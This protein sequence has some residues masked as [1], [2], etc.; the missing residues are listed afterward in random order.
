MI[1]TRLMPV[2]LPFPCCALLA[3][4][5]CSV[6]E[7][8]A[9]Q[10]LNLD[11]IRGQIKA[12]HRE[13]TKDAARE[14][15]EATKDSVTAANNNLQT[16]LGVQAAKLT[17]ELN[18]VKATLNAS[19]Q[20]TADL[21]AEVKLTANAIANVKAVANVDLSPVIQAQ[22]KLTEDL[23]ANVKALSDL[24]AKIDALA[25]AQ[26][27]FNNSMTSLKTEVSAGRDSLVQT[28][29]YSKEA[30]ETVI[31]AQN[32]AL[33]IV[34]A[35]ATLIIAGIKIVAI[36]GYRSKDRDR[37]LDQETIR[38]LVGKRGEASHVPPKS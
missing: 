25:Q 8:S 1:V 32:T 7:Q 16:L 29:Q 33:K 27:G 36:L 6:A 19:I 21:R 14:I 18:A 30:M 9:K 20:A 34:V 38:L 2:A 24:T 35:F 15:K 13:A 3:L 28:T 26:L 12:D 22:A 11:A 17:D 31:N 23:H 37:A 10:D 5:G 4:T